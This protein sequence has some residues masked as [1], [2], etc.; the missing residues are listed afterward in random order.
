MGQVLCKSDDDSI[1]RGL[2]HGA[3]RAPYQLRTILKRGKTAEMKIFISADIE[4]VSG[5]TSWEATRYGGKGYEA[6]CRQMSLET[7]AACRGALSCGYEV[8]V[9]DGHE[10]AMNIDHTLL[11]KEAQLICGW[12]CSPL[13]MLGGLDDTFDGVIYIG[14]HSGAWTDTSP[15]KHTCED[16]VYN[17]FKING[18]F[19]SEF[20][21][22]SGVADQ[23]GVPSL[24]LSGDAGIC[25]AA[26]KEYPGIVTVPTKRGLGDATWNLHPEKVVEDI[27]AAVSNVLSKP[28]PPAHPLAD[29][30][31]MT[32]CYK[33]FQKAMSASWFPGVE[34]IDDFTVSFNAD[35]PLELSRCRYFIG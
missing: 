23:M 15:L 18:E 25:R 22:N 26:E 20:T 24:F 6:A 11:P 7:A 35:K 14:Y 9:K 16:H 29:T 32:V 10:D 31:N 12:T 2:H 17:W 27:E 30:Y 1:G 8:V 4:G 21:I 33:E 19:A 5:I 13:S 3:D 34:K 28:L